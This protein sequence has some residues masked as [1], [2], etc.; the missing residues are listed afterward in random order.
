MCIRVSETPWM[1]FI[2]TALPA[3]V[4]LLTGT[5][6]PVVFWI[7]P[8]V[9]PLV[10][11]FVHVPPAPVT[12]SALFGPVL[13]SRTPALAP[14]LEMRWNVIPAAP[15]F[16]F[17]T[18]RPLPAPVS[19]VLDETVPP[20]PASNSLPVVVS[21]SRP[22]FVKLIVWP[23]LELSVTAALVPVLSVLVVPLSVVD[24]PVLPDR[25]MPPPASLVSPIAPL[26]ATAPPLRP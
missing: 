18:L 8:P 19:I 11:A 22:P 7:W 16:V 5:F 15:T 23:V 17:W 4:S 20:P 9:Q 10:S 13:L 6:A 1:L 21:M 3:G 25:L 14:L 26:R 2:T 12:V 24:P